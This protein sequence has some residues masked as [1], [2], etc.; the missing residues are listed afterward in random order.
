MED[1][2]K[3]LYEILQVSKA[4]TQEE[5]KN[6]Y[7]QLCQQYHPDK[8]PLGTPEQARK[9][10][11]DHFKLIVSAYE[12]LSDSASRENYDQELNQVQNKAYSSSRTPSQSSKPVGF[13]I[14]YE[15]LKQAE[16]KLR[17][18]KEEEIKKTQQELESKKKEIVSEL[19]QENDFSNLNEREVQGDSLII[20]IFQL[21]FLGPVLTFL[22]L[23]FIVIAFTNIPF[24][25]NFMVDMNS[26]VFWITGFLAIFDFLL[27]LVELVINFGI[28][29]F[30]VT[31]I[32]FAISVIGFSLLFHGCTIIR[33]VF[34]KPLLNNSKAKVVYRFREKCK[35]LG[36]EPI[37]ITD[38]RIKKIEESYAKR[39]EFY[40]LK[41][42]FDIT[43]DFVQSLSEEEILFFLTGTKHRLDE[44]SRDKAIQKT[45]KGVGAVALGA[46]FLSLGGGGR[47]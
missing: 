20:K 18:R 11:E 37:K 29:L 27:V 23:V 46:I 22:G 16:E 41:P 33:D 39:T 25:W 9:L 32:G 1:T 10:V 36:E 14:D 5:I 30:M 43:D 13:Q 35:R 44:E 2:Q 45:L 26:Y 8:L 19:L 3:N 4:S 28:R 24:G 7:R 34:Q 47:F 42:L 6:S 38:E 15:K 17:N 40:K 12:V 31:C 21:L